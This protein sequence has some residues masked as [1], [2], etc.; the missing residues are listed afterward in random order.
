MFDFPDDGFTKLP[1][2]RC[3]NYRSKLQGGK[4]KTERKTT[5]PALLIGKRFE[6]TSD[7]AVS[8]FHSE[9]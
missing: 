6:L 2:G 7:F 1:A 4:T 5:S 8:F 9:L 3:R